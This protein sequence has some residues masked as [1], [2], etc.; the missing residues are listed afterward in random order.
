MKAIMKILKLAMGLEYTTVGISVLIWKPTECNIPM[1]GKMILIAGVILLVQFLRSSMS[2]KKQ[3]SGEE[4]FVKDPTT[5]VKRCTC[6]HGFQ[7]DLYGKGMRLHNLTGKK[8]CGR[9]KIARCTVCRKES[10][11]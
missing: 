5:L 4:I 8:G 2:K 9:I 1:V 3:N 6:R 10:T 7:D 11:V